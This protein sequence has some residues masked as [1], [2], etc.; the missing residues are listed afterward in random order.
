M[1]FNAEGEKRKDYDKG[2][3]EKKNLT[4]FRKGARKPQKRITYEGKGGETFE[5]QEKQQWVNAYYLEAPPS[6]NCSVLQNLP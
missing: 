4:L 2:K 3:A 1:G 6:G 5:A